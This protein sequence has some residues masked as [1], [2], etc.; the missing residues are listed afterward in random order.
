MKFTKGNVLSLLIS[1]ALFATVPWPASAALN[2]QHQTDMLGAA[3]TF[4]E[5][6]GLPAR[7]FTISATARSSPGRNGFLGPV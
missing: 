1:I 6:T 5:G 3:S 2:F 7:N 4:Q